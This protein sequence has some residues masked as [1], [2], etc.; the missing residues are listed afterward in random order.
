MAFIPPAPLPLKHSLTSP[1]I[2]TT[3]TIQITILLHHN[4]NTSTQPLYITSPS[5]EPT[6]DFH[7]SIAAIRTIKLLYPP[8]QLITAAQTH[9]TRTQYEPVLNSPPPLLLQSLPIPH[10]L[11]PHHHAITKNP[12]NT[13]APFP[14]SAHHHLPIPQSTSTA[15]APSLF[16]QTTQ[17][18]KLK[19][20]TSPFKPHRHH[21]FISSPTI[22]K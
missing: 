1:Q 5:I 18:C 8:S 3:V 22:P 4:T 2:Q 14:S 15:P 19:P 6:L 17:T 13:R 10:N 16:S 7:Q 11:H 20:T 21:Q 12:Q 9:K